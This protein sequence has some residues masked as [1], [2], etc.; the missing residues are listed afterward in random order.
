MGV[1][2]CGLPLSASDDT[3]PDGMELFREETLPFLS[4]VRDP[5]GEL[6]SRLNSESVREQAI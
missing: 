4:R 3:F 1:H 5:G 2:C 6:G